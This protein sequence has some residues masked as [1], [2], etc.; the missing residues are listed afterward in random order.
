[1]NPQHLI[2]DLPGLLSRAYPIPDDS[3]DQFAGA[4]QRLAETDP[5]Q[6]S[7]TNGAEKAPLWSV[8][9]VR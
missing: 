9:T 7:K 1:M 5:V 4:L 2:T 3:S 6:G 8:I